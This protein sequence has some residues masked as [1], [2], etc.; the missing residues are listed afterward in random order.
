M[1]Y[2]AAGLALLLLA[3]YDPAFR[4]AAYPLAAFFLGHGV[5]SLLH[6]RR[7]H[8]AGY[9]S[10]F[11][12]VSAAVYLAPL[13][14]SLFH[15]ALLV[16]V[17]FGFFLN[18]ARFFTRLRRVLAP[19][20]IAV[21]A[22]SLGAFLYAVGAPL[23]PVAAWGV[24]AGAAAASALGLAGGRRGRFFARRTAL[25]GVLG[26]LLGVLYQVSALVGGLQ[27]FASVAAA[28]VASL[29][30]LGT[31]AKWPRPRLYDDADVL[32]AKR[33]EARFVKTGDVALLA[34]YVAYHLAKAGVEEGR[35]VEVVRA[36]LSYRDW[37]PSPFAPPLVAKLV[38]RANRRRRERHLRK[39]E[40]LLRRYL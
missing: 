11:L 18:A 19:V 20:S 2:I 21:T 39:V 10:T 7:R 13:P 9:F 36:A 1:I 35:V 22:G 12:G 3:Y 15:R 38:E 17:A 14:L 8:V 25:F 6:R 29:L 16:G 34:A 40:A 5:G 4:P 31:E 23:L 26:G 24:G 32:A 28:A 27:L 37:E 30:L 33:V